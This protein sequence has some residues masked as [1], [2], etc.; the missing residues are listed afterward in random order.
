[1]ALRIA[2][3]G[4]G[5]AGCTLARILQ[6]KL[7]AAAVSTTIFEADA[8]PDFRTQGG[9]LGVHD[10]FAQ[11]ALKEAGLHDTFLEHA[12]YDGEAMKLTDKNLL[13]YL[14]SAPRSHPPVENNNDNNNNN[15]NKTKNKRP[16]LAKLSKASPEIDRAEL[17]S[18]LYKSLRK[19]TIFWGKKAARIERVGDG[20]AARTTVHFADGSSE[21]GFDLVVGADGAWS[22]VRPHL[23]STVPFFSGIAGHSF[24]V[25]N[26]AVTAPDT[27][28]LVNR[29]NVFSWSDGRCISLQQLGNGNIQVAAFQVMSGPD[30]RNT[31][32][33]D[34]EDAAQV[35]A[36]VERDFAGWHERLLRPIQTAAVDDA[37]SRVLDLYMLPLGHRWTHKPGVTLIG[38]AAHLMTP[39]AGEGVNLALA[40][41]LHLARGIIAAVNQAGD[42]EGDKRANDN[43]DVARAA[44]DGAVAAF[45]EDMFVRAEASQQLTWDLMQLRF[46][47]PGS[48]RTAIERMML[49]H[50][51]HRLGYWWTLLA[52]PLVYAYY[53][54]F[55]MLWW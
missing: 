32:G 17:R 7:P 15:N 48:P 29:G 19:D 47:T 24:V 9:S 8:S 5:P 12:R 34:V 18:L 51:K 16:P 13:C 42:G 25:P 30:W 55:K 6:H 33:Y 28:A 52:T 53:A 4:A 49:R 35:K 26:A 39:F 20:A 37:Q 10:S 44:L 22:K 3:I 43:D 11:V 21:A 41:S 14:N 38:D 23:S 46:F 54:L 36:S 45:E 1:M 50:L 31:C 40:D 2:I 27:Y